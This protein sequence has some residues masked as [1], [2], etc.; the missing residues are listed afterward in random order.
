MP[1]IDITVINKIAQLGDKYAYAV[2]DN[3]DYAVKWT[4]DEEWSA[5]QVKTAVFAW[6]SGEDY[7]S[8]PTAF[9]GDTCPMPL[10]QNARLCAIGLFSSFEDSEG[11]L[12]QLQTS[13]PRF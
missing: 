1:E 13:T 9:T 10:I 3:T 5:A 6:K 8:V 2:C 11:N 7:Y 12:I 4:L